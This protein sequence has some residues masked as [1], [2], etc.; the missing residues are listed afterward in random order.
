M[1]NRRLLEGLHTILQKMRDVRPV[2]TTQ[3]E[4][5]LQEL[6]QREHLVELIDHY[7]DGYAL[8][9]AMLAQGG[10][11][12]LVPSD[13]VH[14]FR[15]L[16]VRLDENVSWASARER[17]FALSAVGSSLATAAPYPHPQ[18]KDFDSAVSQLLAWEVRAY[19]L[20]SNAS[21]QVP[22]ANV[23]IT[24][25]VVA[26]AM[27]QLVP[28]YED[29]RIE[30]FE[31]ILSGVSKTTFS[32]ATVTARHGRE[33]FV[34]RGESLLPILDEVYLGM[35]L[36]REYYVVR[37][38]HRAGIKAPEPIALVDDPALSSRRFVI[39]RRV[40]GRPP[41]NYLL[42][43]DAISD[44]LAE[45]VATTLAQLHR[46]PIDPRDPDLSRTHIAQHVT[47]T[48]EDAIRD[49]LL[50]AQSY[51]RDSGAPPS[52]LVLVALRWCLENVPVSGKPPCI[53][54]SDCGLNNHLV[55][56]DRVTA[57]VDWETA[58]LSDPA[59]DVVWL[60]FFTGGVLNEEHFLNC[61]VRAGGERP[62]AFAL[63]YFRVLARVR[64][65][66]AQVDVQIKYEQVRGANVILCA[67]ALGQAD[68]T[69][70][71]LDAAIREAEQVKRQIQRQPPAW[72]PS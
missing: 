45:S 65:L 67:M 49:Y 54:H 13:V 63:K 46:V 29:V 26:H 61:Y 66:L 11:S 4:L 9:Q 71:E 25:E 50:R 35:D 41:G 20:A 57:I 28:G 58:R 37:Y 38:L 64:I 8:V 31:P 44:E 72:Q 17:I 23:S 3:A 68:K 14:R 19:R 62:D 16:P 55:E 36:T 52:S 43:I 21:L 10:M 69:V 51:W 5:I 15:S 32:F 1:S 24:A 48:R 53:I 12:A 27:R 42:Q 59:E 30:S 60:M 39:Y 70:A 22:A 2:E 56:N 6:Y 47:H 7:K 33:E 40:P 34:A 18:D